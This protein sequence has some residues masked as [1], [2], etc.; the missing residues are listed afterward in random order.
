MT[1][2]EFR[3]GEF[4]WPAV[5]Q[6]MFSETPVG[7]AV[8]TFDG[9]VVTANPA[10]CR[11]LG[12][13]ADEIIG[14]RA[15]EFVHPD[16][17]ALVDSR[18]AALRTSR[19]GSISYEARI[20]RPDGTVVWAAVNLSVVTV[21][22]DQPLVFGQL[23]DITT[24]RLIE[25]RLALND[26][27]F[28][29]I[30]EHSTDLVVEL[31][32]AGR[33]RYVTPSVRRVLGYGP[34]AF[35]SAFGP[36]LVH[37]ADFQALAEVVER[38][39]AQPGTPL[40]IR[41]R[42]RHADGRWRTLEGTIINLL[43]DPSFEAVVLEARDVTEQ[44]A[45]QEALRRTNQLLTALFESSPI[46]VNVVD[47][48]G[49]VLLW[50][51]AA[52]RLFGWSAEETVGGP[53][54]F[55]PEES[56]EESRALLQASLAGGVRGVEVCRRRKDG[57]PVYLEL[58]TAP[59]RDA[60]GRVTGVLSVT[61]DITARKETEAALRASEERSRTLVEGSFDLITVTAPGGTLTYVS[62]AARE[63][64]GYEP[65]QLIRTDINELVHPDDRETLLRIG[66]ELRAYRSSTRFRYRARHR[67]GTWRHFEA[68]AT[69][70]VAN[71]VVGGFLGVSRDVTEQHRHEQL[72]K[73]QARVL[74]AIARDAEP[75]S[76]LAMIV[77]LVESQIPDSIGSV[78]LAS[79]DGTLRAG[80]GPNVPA[81]IAGI[82]AAGIPVGPD[83]RPCGVAA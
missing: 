18:L 21:E 3:S 65:A 67:D 24:S 29:T 79:D 70:L 80:A 78:L 13:A 32:A 23:I 50:S 45:A 14:H 54:P 42:L 19:T 49:R 69:N 77:E 72:V 58:S 27:R 35:A 34:D 51:P 4:V 5:A 43:A 26:P 1:P 40:S 20:T 73:G 41:G 60:Q 63:L 7:M 28:R 6:T 61:V 11:M 47:T 53:L 44:L 46:P 64:L 59:L 15:H 8:A 17:V 76:T 10:F 36:G 30:V 66:R 2:G 83:S 52:E 16:Q 68:V 71:P 38:S 56:R 81:P 12:R 82:V 9:T 31:D 48:E 62:P 57:A 55:V 25:Q 39:H 74:E 75:E 33:V 37:E 22:R